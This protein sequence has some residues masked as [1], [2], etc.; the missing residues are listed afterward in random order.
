MENVKVIR[1]PEPQQM[2]GNR[3]GY[4]V[5]FNVS[6]FSN[7][8]FK[9]G[10]ENDL[11]SPARQKQNAG[12]AEKEKHIRKEFQYNALERSFHLANPKKPVVKKK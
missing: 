7:E 5:A 10:V 9:N 3:N 6:S 1:P 2:K 12:R 4:V 8:V 11:F